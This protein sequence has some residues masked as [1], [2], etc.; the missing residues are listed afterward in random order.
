[1]NIIL[2]KLSNNVNFKLNNNEYVSID[3]NINLFF[4]GYNINC[5]E[6]LFDEYFIQSH[7]S[8]LNSFKNIEKSESISIGDC[9]R[10]FQSEEKFC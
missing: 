5:F 4:N 3:W 1:M 9:I 6:L 10:E 8:V 7:Y 2:V